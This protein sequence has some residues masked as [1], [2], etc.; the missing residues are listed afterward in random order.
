M[1]R[2]SDYQLYMSSSE[3]KIKDWH[4]KFKEHSW[5]F[6]RKTALTQAHKIRLQFYHEIDCWHWDLLHVFSV[7]ILK[8]ISQL[9]LAQLIG[10]GVKSMG[11]AGGVGQGISTPV[12]MGTTGL[13]PSHGECNLY[14]ILINWQ[15]VWQKSVGF[16]VSRNASVEWTV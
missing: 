3:S 11:P 1:S 9:E 4:W 12:S 16:S 13:V 7:Q 8:C 15:C 5:G 14:N 2:S 10:T 6:H